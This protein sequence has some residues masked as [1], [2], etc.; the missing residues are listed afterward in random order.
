MAHIYSIP[1]T[2]KQITE[3]SIN[4]IPGVFD[5]NTIAVT[6]PAGT[7]N[8]TSLRANFE[9]TSEK[10]TVTVNG[11]LQISGSTRNDFSNPVEYVVTAEDESTN[12]YTVIVEEE[13][14]FLSYGFEQLLPPVYASVSGY[15]LTVLVLQGTPV[16]SLVA[17]FVT[18]SQ[19]PTVKIGDLEQTSGITLNDFS[20][21]L[22]YTLE[23][24]NKSV[25]YTIRVTV[26][27]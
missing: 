14:G 18:T 27:K 3:Y 11:V 22:I 16:D 8:F 21:P 24:D 19:N 5:G 13:I 12:T 10:A 9:T 6:M 4:N 2:A 17:S 15:D 7:N 26:I 23:A 20:K 25:D 1:D